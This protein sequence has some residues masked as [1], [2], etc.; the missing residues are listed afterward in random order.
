M[1]LGV[2][3]P[4]RLGGSC[5]ESEKTVQRLAAL[6]YDWHNVMH[7]IAALVS[8]D[9]HRALTEQQPFDP[10]DYAR[11]LASLPGD[12]PSPQALGLL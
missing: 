1:R 8:E 11:R 5:G 4:P 2:T 10:G 9:I 7:M 12:W 6:G 3:G